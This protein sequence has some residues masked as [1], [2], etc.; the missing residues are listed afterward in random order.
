MRLSGRRRRGAHPRQNADDHPQFR[1]VKLAAAM[2]LSRVVLARE[3]SRRRLPISAST[4]PSKRRF[5]F[6]APWHENS[7][8]CYMSAVIGRAAET[9]ACAP[10]V[11]LIM[12][13]AARFRVPLKPEGQLP[14]RF[15]EE[16]E[17][18]ALPA[19]K[20][21]GACAAR[22]FG[23]RHRIYSRVVKDKKPR[24]P[25]TCGR[26]EALFP[27]GFYQRLLPRQK[28]ER[29]LGVAWRRREGDKV[30]LRHGPEKTIS[31][32]NSSACPSDLPSDP[33]GQPESLRWW[34]TGQ[35][36]RD[37]GAD[38]DPGVSQGLTPTM[39]KRSSIR[40]GTPF[41]C[42]GVRSRWKEAC[43]PTS[44]INEMRR[45]VL[46]ELLEK[47]KYLAPRREGEFIPAT[48]I[49]TERTSRS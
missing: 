43:V 12:P 19:S 23:H 27:Q 3:L 32:A 49:S 26:S 16:I 2:G 1:G 18:S 42:I 15:L 30:Y 17:S 6:T 13:P 7:G 36:R 8:Q 29:H 47:R 10:A 22:V 20:S 9:A 25:T 24:L 5:L 39:Y 44:A 33:A 37:A 14:D 11:R 4:P 46:A 34:T 35:Q 28:G 45:D 31:T 48:G 40:R 21:K 41:Y 38:A